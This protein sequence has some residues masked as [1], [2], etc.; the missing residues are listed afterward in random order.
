MNLV[1]FLYFLYNCLFNFCVCFCL[2]F[3][4][5][6][7]IVYK[8]YVVVIVNY[9]FLKLFFLRGNDIGKFVFFLKIVFL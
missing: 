7:F 9:D 4:I 5:F 1:L 2:F 8:G 3:L 6:L